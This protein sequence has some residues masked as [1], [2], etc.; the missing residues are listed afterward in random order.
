LP[1]ALRADEDELTV[2]CRA[3]Q[4][5]TMTNVTRA[6]ARCNRA[7]HNRR[8]VPRQTRAAGSGRRAGLIHKGLSRKAGNA[9][10]I[11]E[12]LENVLV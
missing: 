5:G 12:T 9:Q 3:N 2:E 10:D 7:R 4:P 1:L 11:D 6:P 8:L